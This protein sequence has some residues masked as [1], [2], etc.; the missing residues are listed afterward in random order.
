MRISH[1]LAGAAL[2]C[3]SLS[4]AAARSG[5][6]QSGQPPSAPPAVT[7]GAIIAAS[8][9]DGHFYAEPSD[10]PAFVQARSLR[11]G[12]RC[13]FDIE[14]GG[15][16]TV[17]PSRPGA[18][19]PGD[20]VGCNTPSG[21]NQITLYATRYGVPTSTSAQLEEAVVAIR[22]RF[23]VRKELR[24]T[25][26]ARPHD[27]GIR[28]FLICRDDGVL[29]TRVAVAIVDGWVLKMRFTGAEAALPT[30]DKLWAEALADF[31]GAGRA[32][33]PGI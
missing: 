17:F 27:V 14:A 16:I 28:T 19:A 21:A 13:R 9:A 29:A 3:T 23:E 18:T 24:A 5:P 11:S 1:A 2:V 22:E 12:L 8:D 20:D 30:A 4:S 32:V 10:D 26:P 6:L 15:R 31:E 33:R 25:T 7:A